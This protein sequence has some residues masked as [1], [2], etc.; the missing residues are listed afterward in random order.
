MTI[1][2]QLRQ[3]VTFWQKIIAIQVEKWLILLK[4]CNLGPHFHDLRKN[5]SFYFFTFLS[6]QF[7][8]TNQIPETGKPVRH[9]SKNK[10]LFL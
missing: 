6:I 7:F 10:N 5:E 8:V 4:N 9:H 3:M 1:R 2:R